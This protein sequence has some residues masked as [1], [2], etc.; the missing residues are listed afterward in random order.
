[1]R[2]RGRG[3]SP[4]ATAQRTASAG[5]SKVASTPSPDILTSL[6]PVLLRRQSEPG[7]FGDAVRLTQEF[8]D[9]AQALSDR[10]GED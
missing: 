4:S 8:F 10:L 7:R 6:S 5:P 9:V 3:A 2:P 1:M